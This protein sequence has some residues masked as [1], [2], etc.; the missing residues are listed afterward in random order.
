MENRSYIYN[1][2]HVDVIFGDILSSKMRVIA[3]SQNEELSLE[4]G[5]WG[6][7]LN[8]ASSDIK[9]DLNKHNRAKLGDVIITSA[10]HL[11]Q[12][13]IFHCVTIDKELD[14]TPNY[15]LSSVSEEDRYKHIIQDCVN[16]CFNY[17]HLLEIDSIAF[18]IIE[19]G[20][21]SIS[22][23]KV[24]N[25]WADVIAMNLSRTNKAITVELYICDNYSKFTDYDYI[26]LFESL[27][28]KS[29][30]LEYHKSF[31]LGN[32]IV[33]TDFNNFI[34]NQNFPYWVAKIQ[35]EYDKKSNYQSLNEII[36]S[37]SAELI[38]KNR[39]S[40][41]YDIENIS[42]SVDESIIDSVNLA[43]HDVFIS[44]ARKDYEEADK[45]CNLI[46][47]HR[48]SYWIDRKGLYGSKNFKEM[49]ATAIQNSKVV[50]FLS[51][52]NSNASQ[53]VQKEVNFAVKYNKTILPIM[54][55][56]SPFAKS[57]DFDIAYCQQVDYQNSQ[58]WEKDLL[59]S[60]DIMLH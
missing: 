46:E 26:S 58:N 29:A 60:L 11:L 41:F 34:N 16:R 28:S 50:V 56:H 45:I 33:N 10:G 36:E 55:D 5:V 6:Q 17:M 25:I 4:N 37:K 44:Y 51:S 14:P 24:C 22:F 54:L 19:L 38:L 30:I 20:I 3:T 13:Y 32:T 31:E 12:E 1:K 23:V 43:Q 8:V 35:A 59:A 48:Y 18:P 39:G 2:S 57:I 49:I 7:I 27:A 21:R 40:N 52:I 53:N 9:F 42:D 47:T 15:N